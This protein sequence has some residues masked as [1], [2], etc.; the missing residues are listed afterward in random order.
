MSDSTVTGSDAGPDAPGDLEPA[1]RTL[2]RFR[3]IFAAVRSHFQ[4]VEK[5]AGIGGA[6]FWALGLIHAQPGIRVTELA[7][8]MH[9]HQSTAS[10]L[11][12]GLVE[13]DLIATE[14]NDTDRRAVQLH[15]KDAGRAVLARAPGP[16]EGVL[17]QAL[18]RLDAA[19]LERM[20]HDLAAL[21]ASL[22]V[23]SDAPATPLAQL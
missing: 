8:A 2:R 7:R 16:Y 12:R 21:V 5:R 1:T 10:N 6:Q 20:E 17:P 15:L 9:V 4:Q 3:Q 22:E 19:T 18:A 11:V 13:R 14:R 23:D